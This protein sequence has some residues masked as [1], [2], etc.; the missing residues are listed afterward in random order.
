MIY[1]INK[2]ILLEGSSGLLADMIEAC[3]QKVFQVDK[4]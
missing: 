2:Q 3:G 4:K 1:K